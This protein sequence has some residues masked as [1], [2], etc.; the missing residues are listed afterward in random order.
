MVEGTIDTGRRTEEEALRRV[1][2]T[3]VGREAD[4]P[5]WGT[6]WAELHGEQL[7]GKFQ[8]IDRRLAFVAERAGDGR[9]DPDRGLDWACR[10][11][12]VTV[13]REARDVDPEEARA[14]WENFVGLLVRRVVDEYLNDP[15]AQAEAR[16]RP[17]MLR[18]HDSLM[19]AHHV[20][21]KSDNAF[22]RS[23]RLLQAL[24]REE[25]GL[26]IGQHRGKPLGT[27]LAMPEAQEKLSNYLTPTIRQVVER[28]VVSA[29]RGR[30]KLFSKP[31]IFNDLLSSQPLC[32]NLFGE[33]AENLELATR[34]FRRL[35]PERIGAVEGIDFESSPGRRDEKYT[36]DNSAFDVFVRYR[37]V[38]GE[39]GFIG[40]EV[41]YHEA[42]K[43][44]PAAHRRR[45][46]E[47]ARGLEAFRG[48][49]LNDLRGKP[50][51][52]I[53]RDHLLAGSMLLAD[54]TW[55]EGTFAFLYPRANERCSM[56]VLQYETCLREGVE[57][58]VPWELEDVV[59]AL[60][61]ETAADWVAMVEDRY[62]AFGK[63]DELF[64]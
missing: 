40:I 21:V 64:G 16:K 8:V 57:S 15:V 2:F 33:L 20:L 55:A 3:W 62:V 42:L 13:M 19:K 61:A 22:Q 45:Y 56:A 29:K 10:D 52:Q 48:E 30:G 51:Q 34:V 39:A 63:V 14:A 41:K 53:W 4:D 38:K 11:G 17:R 49:R 12:F 60:R 58:F 18:P 59:E 32:F 5:A 6:G 9:E 43:D 7:V 28:E 36:G 46:D 35:L 54:A 23:A 27:R 44:K 31:R 47:V 1:D 50:L 25:Q 24:W 26:P 37:T